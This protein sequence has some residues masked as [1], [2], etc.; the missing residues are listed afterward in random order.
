MSLQE[1]SKFLDDLDWAGFYAADCFKFLDREF[2]A[3]VT[4]DEFKR[5]QEFAWEQQSKG[6]RRGPP[7]RALLEAFRDEHLVEHE[8]EAALAA[9]RDFL[10]DDEDEDEGEEEREGHGSGSA[11]ASGGGNNTNA[12]DEE[13]AAAADVA[14]SYLDGLYSRLDDGSTNGNA[15]ANANDNE[16]SGDA[17][18]DADAESESNSN[19]NSD[20][21]SGAGS[22]SA[23]AIPP[24]L[25]LPEMSLSRRLEHPDTKLDEVD[26][27]ILRKA[28]DEV[29]ADA[30][31]SLSRG[32]L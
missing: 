25:H 3:R 28:F 4:F 2:D 32:E 11:S 19:S 12:T 5:W 13:V 7:K 17:D 9:K 18:A 22:G 27:G 1:V 23:G 15:N 20:S 14:R 6:H 30:N 24:Q 21:G 16:N 31:G 29:D 8:D 26:V 10:S